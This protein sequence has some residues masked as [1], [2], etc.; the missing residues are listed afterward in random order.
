MT[1]L[2]GSPG[3]LAAYP[4]RQP[5]TAVRHGQSRSRTAAESGARTRLLRSI[6]GVL[7]DFENA[8]AWCTK[9]SGCLRGNRK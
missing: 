1:Y 8:S 4:K 6:Q 2:N 3:L 9:T 7:P 5:Y